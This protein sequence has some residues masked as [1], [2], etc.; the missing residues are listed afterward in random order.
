MMD[1]KV[2]TAKRE[3]GNHICDGGLIPFNNRWVVRDEQGN[4]VDHSRY[5]NDLRAL[6]ATNNSTIEFEGI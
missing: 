1:K 2:Y 4:Y 5:S 6:Y 3:N